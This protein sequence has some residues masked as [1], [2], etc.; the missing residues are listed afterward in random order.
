MAASGYKLFQATEYDQIRFEWEITAQSVANNT[1]VIAWK[2][3]LVAG[4]PGRIYS[5]V[6][7]LWSVTVDGETTEGTNYISVE[8]NETRELASGTKTISHST[9]GS[10][11]FSFSFSQQFRVNFGGAF[12]DT[13]SGSGTGTL[14]RIARAST[15]TASNGTLDVEQ[16]LTITRKDS[17][18]KHRL[19]YKCGDVSEYIAGS[20]SS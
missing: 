8:N 4:D 15:L 5:S 6:A 18:F 9:D 3:L 2:L 17:S 10:K 14:D 19:T 7:K 12:I 11:T 1:S 16:T 13:V 20:T